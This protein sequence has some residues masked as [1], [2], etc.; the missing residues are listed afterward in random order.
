LK[1]FNLIEGLQNIDDKTIE[2]VLSIKTKEDLRREKMKEKKNSQGNKLKLGVVLIPVLCVVLIGIFTISTFN[3]DTRLKI[4]NPL[5]EVNSITEMKNYLGFDVPVL[6]TKTVKSYIVIG[7]DNDEYAYH[8]RIIYN[9][10]AQF[11][12]E[13]G[14]TDV[15]G[16]YGGVKEKEQTINNI[17][18]TILTLDNTRYAIWS[19]NDYSYSYSSTINDNNFTVDLENIVS[20]TQ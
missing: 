16:F 19:N 10:D 18:V 13:K 15:S 6:K 3:K 11:E 4:N 14:N 8:G 2:R 12:I 20:L 5:T 7:D 1:K 9:N 17:K